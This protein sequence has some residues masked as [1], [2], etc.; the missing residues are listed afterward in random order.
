[1][2][3][4]DLRKMKWKE[5]SYSYEEWLGTAFGGQ[6]T[7]RS[8]KAIVGH[9]FL[10]ATSKKKDKLLRECGRGVKNLI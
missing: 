6:T 8:T 9:G 3:E 2:T 10:R 4:S 5:I 7:G 1:M